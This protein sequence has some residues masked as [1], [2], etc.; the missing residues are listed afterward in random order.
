[1]EEHPDRI[2][3]VPQ[4]LLTYSIHVSR[5]LL[6]DTL[7]QIPRMLIE[8]ILKIIYEVASCPWKDSIPRASQS[9]SLA[10]TRKTVSTFHSVSQQADTVEDSDTLIW[11]ILVRAAYGGMGGDIQMLRGFAALWDTRFSSG[12]IPKN[13]ASVREDEGDVVTWNQIPTLIHN[14]ASQQS[15]ARVRSLAQQGIPYLTLNDISVEGI[16]FHCSPILENILSDRFLVEQCIDKMR[17]SHDIPGATAD[18]RSF[19]EGQLKSWI[20]D[21]SAGVNRRRPLVPSQSSAAADENDVVFKSI[22]TEILHP[23]VKNFQEG[24]TRNRLAR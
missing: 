12:E 14:A 10:G 21:Y 22:W 19:L 2:A 3:E 16:D 24:Y 18:R 6:F 17:P 20:W 13:V 15:L 8:R 23:K 11:S 7:L 5:F 9:F 4:I 1:M